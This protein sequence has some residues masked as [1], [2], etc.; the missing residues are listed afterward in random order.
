[1]ILELV[2]I[3][4]VLVAIRSHQPPEPF[5][6]WENQDGFLGENGRKNDRPKKVR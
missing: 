5:N 1:M 4:V 6:T 3:L 2:F